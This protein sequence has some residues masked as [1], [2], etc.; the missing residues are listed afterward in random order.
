M[1]PS[2]FWLDARIARPAGKRIALSL[3]PLWSAE[4]TKL[5]HATVFDD[6]DAY[7][8]EARSRATL[9]NYDCASRRRGWRIHGEG[10]FEQVRRDKR[11]LRMAKVA[12]S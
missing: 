2:H 5:S 8:Y 9:D 4:T 3:P 1:S 10:R 12:L 7:G 6:V 11:Q